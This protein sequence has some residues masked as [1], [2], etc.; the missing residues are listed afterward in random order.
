[1]DTLQ[2]VLGGSTKGLTFKKK[3]VEMYME[4]HTFQRKDTMKLHCSKLELQ[5]EE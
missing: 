4:I 3:Q 1:M 2:Y 5:E